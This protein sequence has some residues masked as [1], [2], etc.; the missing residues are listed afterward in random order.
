MT[1]NLS[2]DL[3]LDSVSRYL[4][5]KGLLAAADLAHVEELTGGVSN[6]AFRIDWAVG[7]CVVKQARAR[8]AV[9]MEWLADVRRV[10]REGEAMEWLR[11]RLG[12]PHIPRL[13]YLDR[14]RNLLVMEAVPY[15]AENY[16]T[17]LLRGEVDLALAGQFGWLLARIHNGTA[18]LESHHKFGDATFFDELRL[19]PYYDQAAER[20]PRLAPRIQ[21]LRREC[22]ES[23]FCLVH[24]DYSPK[25]VLVLHGRLILLDY[26]VAHFGNPS[27]DLGFALTHYLAKALHVPGRGTEFI[28]AARA[29]WDTYRRDIRIAPEAI[30]HAGQHLGAILLARMDGKSPLEYFT[31]P[32]KQ[33]QVRAI[34]SAALMDDGMD[35]PAVIAAVEERLP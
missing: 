15:A 13:L 6:R 25:N 8:L 1:S 26:E 21:A 35:I 34:A 24:G 17:I 10:I 23:V 19:S 31:D 2:G 11:A 3:T 28:A 12:G 18:D 33:D 27:F 22:R 20:H 30:A 9:Q 14:E 32:R 16:K 4:S 7:G 29:F 5:Q